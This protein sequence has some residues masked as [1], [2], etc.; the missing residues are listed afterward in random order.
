MVVADR[1]EP[2]VRGAAVGKDVAAAVGVR[3]PGAGG[4]EDSLFDR[5]P[6][7]R[8]GALGPGGHAGD[9]RPQMRQCQVDEGERAGRGGDGGGEGGQG[10]V[11]QETDQ[12]S[13]DEAQEG[14]GDGDDPARVEGREVG[15]GLGGPDA[16]LSGRPGE[17]VQRDQ[18]A[19]AGGDEGG[20]G[21]EPDGEPAHRGHRLRPGQLSGARLQLPAGQRGAGPG[22]DEEGGGEDGEGGDGVDVLVANDRRLV[23][24]A[25]RRFATGVVLLPRRPGGVG[26]RAAQPQQSGREDDHESRPDVQRGAVQP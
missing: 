20:R 4:G 18:Q 2:V 17:V 19:G 12:H 13:D 9:A 22:G 16:A 21:G 7:A 8:R 26:E 1:V 14:Q 23:V 15:P 25:G 3:Q 6:P 10:A 5:Q 24:D 11:P